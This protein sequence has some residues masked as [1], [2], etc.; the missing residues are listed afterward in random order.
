MPDSN[1]TP[2]RAAA[3]KALAAA[4][5]HSDIDPNAQ[6]PED[7]EIAAE[8]ILWRLHEGGYDVWQF[9]PG[10]GEEGGGV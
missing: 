5:H 10:K 4:L 2:D 7:W 3:I 6:H 1:A 8:S 9:G